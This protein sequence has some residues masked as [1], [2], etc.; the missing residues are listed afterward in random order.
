MGT[1]VFLLIARAAKTKKAAKSSG[2]QFQI[3]SIQGE[4]SYALVT[5]ESP[6]LKMQ[7][8]MFVK[9]ESSAKAQMGYVVEKTIEI[10]CGRN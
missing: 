5:G 10:K 6:V 1:I 8:K 3:A 7:E 4:G 2:K 9:M